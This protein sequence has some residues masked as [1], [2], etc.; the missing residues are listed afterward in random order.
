M[1]ANLTIT[2][3]LCPPVLPGLG[4]AEEREAAAFRAVIDRTPDRWIAEALALDYDFDVSEFGGADFDLEFHDQASAAIAAVEKNPAA[5]AAARARLYDTVDTY[6][7]GYCGPR[8]DIQLGG[9]WLSIY[10]GLSCGDEPFDGYGA[11][12]ALA[13][14]PEL[15]V[16]QIPY[17][18]QSLH[19]GVLAG[20]EDYGGLDDAAVR[21]IKKNPKLLDGLIS[22]EL[23]D[24]ESVIVDTVT[25]A[26][27][28]IEADARDAVL[29]RIADQ[30]AGQ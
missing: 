1:G 11:V 29:A 2:L 19:A 14:L 15:S 5:M 21:W 3:H 25:D 30:V 23:A 20:I 10:G 6:A 12:C 18:P 7:V 24:R 9:R 26:L 8:T 16:W 22:T 28:G 27:A 17:I 4:T 13:E